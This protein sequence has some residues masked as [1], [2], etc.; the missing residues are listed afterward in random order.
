MDRLPAAI[1]K[2]VQQEQAAGATIKSVAA[3]KEDG[4]TVYQIETMLKGH[5][6]DLLVDGTGKIIEVE[7]EVAIDTVPV[8]VRSALEA[9]GRVVK[10]E[11]VTKGTT[12]TYEAQVEKNGKR[13][14]VAV[15]ASGKRVK[16]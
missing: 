10:V 15:D 14:E 1:Q 12:V 6:R 7:E 11:T 5:A 16:T 13:L 2:A 3:E 8:P 4:K 9:L